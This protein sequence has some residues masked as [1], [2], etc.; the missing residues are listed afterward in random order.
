MISFWYNLIIKVIKTNGDEIMKQRIKKW[1]II[2]VF[3]IFALCF[4]LHYGYEKT[5][6]T[7]LA[8]VCPVNESIWEH[9]RMGFYA[10][11]IYA[12]VEYFLIGKEYKNF[13]YGKLKAVYIMPITIIMLYY[14]YTGIIG[15]HF[16]W[17]DIGIAF[18]GAILAQ[19]ISYSTIISSKD[20]K[21]RQSL[22]LV[23]I[24]IGIIVF[25]VFVFSPPKLPLFFDKKANQYGIPL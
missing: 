15:K 5:E 23:F 18:I 4:P 17:M 1:E 10:V 13:W 3:I 25:T 16:I 24:V 11:L 12:V 21:K 19:Y 20:F 8:L 2:G 6:N 9:A 14:T 7:L 22:S